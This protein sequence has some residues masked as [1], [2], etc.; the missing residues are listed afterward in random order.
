MRITC[1]RNWPRAGPLDGGVIPLSTALPLTDL[2]FPPG[3]D[4]ADWKAPPHTAWA[5]RNVARFLPVA[6][7][8]RGGR[9]TSLTVDPEPLDVS[10]YLKAVHATSAIVIRAGRIVFEAYAQGTT[11][12]DRPMLFSITKSLLGLVTLDLI[13]SGAL[14]PLKP[15][16]D[17]VPELAGTAFGPA[18]IADLLAMRDGI[19]FDEGYG[20]P[21]AEIHRYSRH[22][23]GSAPGGTLAALAALPP[24]DA[25]PGRFGYRTPVAD[26][27]GWVARR[28]AGMPLSTLISE[29]LWQRIGAEDDALMI[30]DTAG[31]E[32][33]GTGF[34][35]R[36]RDLARLAL[37]LLDGG[38]S[39]ISPEITDTLFAGGDPHAL[40]SVAGYATRAGW[41]YT[42]LWWHMGANR[43]AALGVHGQRL[44][45]DRRAQL[46]LIVTAAAPTPDSRPLDPLHHAMFEAL[47]A[48]RR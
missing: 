8:P 11:A 25:E 1:W 42:G 28:A 24:R 48:E 21:E 41:S 31:Q 5:L 44:M 45:I 36:P 43:I 32:I 10:D 13:A 19:A 46:A 39:A 38:G 27:I 40:S 9:V 16:A 23:W 3:F 33:G 15:A 29:R 34:C 12:A 7:V 22:Y 6:S 35:A 4:R 37:A 2:S 17:Y 26:V 47:A 30:R 14:D 18:R 20:D